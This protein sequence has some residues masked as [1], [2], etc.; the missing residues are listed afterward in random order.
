MKEEGVLTV[1]IN[2]NIATVQT[3]KGIAD[4]IY[5]LPVTVEYVEKVI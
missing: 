3:A 2:P 4:Q 1:L 5:Y